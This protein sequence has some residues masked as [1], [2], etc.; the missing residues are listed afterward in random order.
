MMTGAIETS[1]IERSSSASGITPAST[2]FDSVNSTASTI[3]I[4]MPTTKP[5]AASFSDTAARSKS[6]SR[7]SPAVA[8]ASGSVTKRKRHTSS[9]PLATYGEIFPL[10]IS[11]CHA[12]STMPTVIAALSSPLPTA[13]ST[14]RDVPATLPVATAG[15]VPPLMACSV[16]RPRA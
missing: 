14:A 3:A 16:R 11:A 9:G 7:R 2:V 1:G 12:A 13:A 15:P 5:I 10:M 6:S 8:R 4:A